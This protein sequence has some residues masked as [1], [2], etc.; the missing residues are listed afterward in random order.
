MSE[1]KT[2]MTYHVNDFL[3]WHK[4]GELTLSPKYQRNSVW[5]EKAKSY[6]IDTIIEGFPIPQIFMRQQIDVVAAKTMREIIDGQQRLR[7]ILGY[8]EGKFPI[9]RIHNSEFGGMYYDDLD[10]D[11]KEKILGF[12]LA[13]E[14]I[15]SNDDS[16]IYDMFARLNTNSV[17]LNKQELRNARF[18]GDYKVFIYQIT[19]EIK[20]L[21]LQIKTFSDNQVARMADAE[22]ISTLVGLSIDGI[23]YETPSIIDNYYKKYDNSFTP[24]EDIKNKFDEVFKIISTVV[25]DGFAPIFFHRKNSIYTLYA[26]LYHQ[27]FG[28]NNFSGV[29]DN[30][31][32]SNNILTNLQIFKNHLE[33][34]ESLIERFERNREEL[35][36]DDVKQIGKFL[37][38]HKTR[39]TGRQE[40][41]ERVTFLNQYICGE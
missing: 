27:L 32:D 25:Q 33:D 40:R 8:I 12:E 24:A 17:T 22:L 31:F 4:Q 41:S 1:L 26:V 11:I 13:V 2:T 23:I 21:L 38:Y 15:K 36:N 39:T 3:G 9:S 16:L 18:W 10:T 34:L 28:L 20:P 29:R 5:N 30:R 19:K 7:T 35:N 14:V 6:L 37:D